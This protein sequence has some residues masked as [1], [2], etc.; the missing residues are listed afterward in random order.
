MRSATA[1]ILIA[2]LGILTALTACAAGGRNDAAPRQTAAS[3][4]AASGSAATSQTFN[5]WLADLRREALASGISSTTFD[6]AFA[7]ITPDPE[8]IRLDSNQPEFSRSVWDYLDAAVSERRVRD[9]RARLAEQ[10]AILDPIGREYGVDPRFIVAIWGLESGFGANVGSH[11]V[12]RSLATLAYQ[13]RRKA[14]FREFLLQALEILE[15]G[16]IDRGRMVGSWAGAMGQTQFMPGPY[17]EYAIDRD[18]DGQRDLWASLPDVFA[19]TANYLDR[20]GW[21]AGEGWGTEVV[22]PD[23]FDYALA[24]RSIER[25]VANWQ[26]LGVRTAT[27]G[28]FPPTSA[29]ASIILPAGHRGP[30]FMIYRNF[31]TIM[32]Y[33]ASTSYALAVG[34]LADRIGGGGPIVASWPRD[35]RPLSRSEREDLQ[36]LLTGLGYDTEGVDGIIGPNTRS[37]LRAYQRDRG[38]PADGF[39]TEQLLRRLRTGG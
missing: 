21:A 27:G 10:S 33:N 19:S 25:G 26:T 34:H 22:L 35:E 37:A 31:R 29:P 39:P 14:A 13:G 5:A 36:R 3:A 16:H 32:R 23:G 15:A 1:R 8:V 20:H 2:G 30:A 11:D 38:L 4:S 24:D 28:P 12:I 17:L 6:A 7:G 18:G 9:G